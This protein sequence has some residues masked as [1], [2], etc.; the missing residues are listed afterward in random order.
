VCKILLEV[1]AIYSSVG[2]ITYTAFLRNSSQFWNML[3]W[4]LYWSFFFAS[5]WLRKQVTEAG[6]AGKNYISYHYV[7]L[8]SNSASGTFL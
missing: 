2:V 8:F 3:D 7:Q 6:T 1:G 5:F 4:H